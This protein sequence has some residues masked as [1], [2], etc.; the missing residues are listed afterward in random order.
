MAIQKALSKEEV[1]AEIGRL[2]RLHPREVLGDVVASY[3]NENFVPKLEKKD[4]NLVPAAVIERMVCDYFQ[5]SMDTL[6]T[7]SRS[8]NVLY[9]RQMVHFFLYRHA[10]LSATEIGR[11]FEMDHTSIFSSVN[12]I[13]TLCGRRAEVQKDFRVLEEQFLEIKKVTP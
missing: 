3:I 1:R 2:V 9:P 8:R 12:R 4:G 5:T 6:K 7:R 10:G 13:M 11:R